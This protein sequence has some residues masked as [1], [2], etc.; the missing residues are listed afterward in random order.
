MVYDLKNRN[1]LVTGGSRGLGAEAAKR[2]AGE[3]CNI[4]VNYVSSTEVAEELAK[5]LMAG[6]GVKAVAI[7]GYVPRSKKKQPLHHALQP[8]DGFGFTNPGTNSDVSTQPACAKLINDTV[9]ALGGLDI[10]ISNAGWTKVAPF[11]HAGLT[12]LSEEDWDRCWDTNVKATLHLTLAAHPI[13]SR[14]PQG[15][16]VLVSSSAA[17]TNCGGSSIA[18]S[19]S[20]AAGLHLVKCLAKSLGPDGIRVNAVQ[21]GLLLTDWGKG[22]GKATEKMLTARSPL[23]VLPT[24]EDCADV[25]LSLARG[26]TI[27]GAN[28]R[29]DGGAFEH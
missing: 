15:G 26:D 20:K 6:Y 5:G 8:R 19:V 2:F 24:V 11:S 17:A 10:I 21:P 22:L 28:I 4:V 9:S 16:V 13:L 12:T 27:T 18:Y 25:F 7:Q 29:V 23:G 3:G 1:V 14:N